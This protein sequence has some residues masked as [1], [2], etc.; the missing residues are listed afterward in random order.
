[1][2]T[3][4]N[5]SRASLVALALLG[6]ALLAGVSLW[7]NAQEDV[8]QTSNPDLRAL[9]AQQ[10]SLGM[11]VIDDPMAKMKSPDRQALEMLDIT[12]SSADCELR[13]A[14]DL[15]AVYENLQSEV[16]RAM[17]KPLLADRLRLYSRLLGFDAQK[18]ALPLGP[19]S[20]IKLETTSKKALNLRDDVIAA[21]N[22]LDS[23]A[24]SLR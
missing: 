3:N 9:R 2:K 5:L 8:L 7:L 19:P 13:A 6:T 18:A 1:M 11:F 14:I 21:K 17:M 24:A 23:I 20:I 4:S 22:K 12:A 15:L 16:D 10:T